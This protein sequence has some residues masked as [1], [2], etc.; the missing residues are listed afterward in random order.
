M[1]MVVGES[2]SLLG[3]WKVFE[4]L[5]KRE[6]VATKIVIFPWRDAE[7]DGIQPFQTEVPRQPLYPYVTHP[8][9]VLSHL[10]R[11]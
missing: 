4:Q 11:N 7:L 8:P 2:H 9:L 10:I 3:V 1:Y 5:G 6:V